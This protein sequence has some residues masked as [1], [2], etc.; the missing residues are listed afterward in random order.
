MAQGARARGGALT[1]MANDDTTTGSDPAQSTPPPSGLRR[2]VTGAA[3]MVGARWAMRSIGLVSTIILARLLR[4]EDF[5]LVAMGAITVQFV[6]VFADAGQALAVIRDVN[7]TNEHF[8]TAWT[9]S[10]IIGAVV[11]AVLIAGAPL[12]GWYFHDPRAVLV[13]QVVAL[14][15]FI[16]GF[17]NVGVLAFRKDLRFDKDFQ[18]LVIQRFSVFV[19]GVTF[20]FILRNYWALV[21]GNVGGEFLNV[22][23]SYRLSPYRPRFRLTRLSEIWRYSVWMQLANIGAFFGETADQVVVGGM[24]GATPM[25]TYNVAVDVASAPTNE[26][27]IPVARALFP[28]YATLLDQPERF[29]EAYLGVL[30]AVA[31]IALSTGVGVALV[32]HDLVAVVLGAKWLAAEPLVVWLALG[33]AVL[34]VA[35]S[36]NAVLSVSGSGRIYAVRNWIFVAML[37]PAA[38][39]GGINW[40]P[41]GIAVART[42]VTAVFAPIMFYTVTRVIPVRAS[43]ILARLWRPAVAA[44]VMAAA[45]ELSGTATIASATLRLFCNAGLGAAVFTAVLLALWASAGRP[46]GVEKTAVAQAGR[47][48]R[49]LDG[50]RF[51]FSR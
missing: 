19:A 20:A 24:T 50:I 29:A 8:D 26:L 36:S 4:P 34:G 16:N 43:E 48:W 15:P 46:A 6:R 30:S 12:A 3:W 13:V 1:D 22:L 41:L 47:L 28:F 5:G 2:M 17:T 14:K 39:F 49:R 21:I 40:G 11:A 10:V 23:I 38:V 18:F 32:A 45:V 37:V 7:A 25:G 9:M 35:R 51:S 42:A 27:V 44:S 31:V 33:S